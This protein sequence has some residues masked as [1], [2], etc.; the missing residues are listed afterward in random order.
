MATSYSNFGG[1]GG[2]S[3]VIGVTTNIALG[4]TGVGYLVNGAYG[5][6]LWF[7]T[8]SVTS[9]LYL[10]FQFTS[11]QNGTQNVVIDEAKWYQ[12]NATAQG[13][14]QWQGSNDGSSWTNIGANFTLGGATTEIITTLN[15]NT[16]SY[17]YYQMIGVSGSTNSSPFTQAIDF[18]IDGFA[19]TAQFPAATIYQRTYFTQVP[20]LP[21]MAYQRTY[22]TVGES[23]QGY[24][25][26]SSL[27][28]YGLAA[29]ATPTG[30][31]P[32]PV[33]ATLLGATKGIAYSETIS[34]QGGSSPYTF[35]VSIGALPTG[36]SLNSSTGV[37]SGTPTVLGTSNFTIRVTDSVAATG[38]QPFSITVS[39]PVAANYGYFN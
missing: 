24:S 26:P 36:L 9:S 28:G 10:Q 7:Q 33:A 30:A 6:V 35:T 13:V 39:A 37:I 12:N 5:N 3:A 32:V 29:P 34:A 18:K 21:S 4:G 15:G 8:Q 25:I 31:T 22:F 16:T 19:F 38:T 23:N 20:T 11:A 27:F 1:V 17:G 14:W 2:R